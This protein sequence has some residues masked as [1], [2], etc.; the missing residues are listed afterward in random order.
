MKRVEHILSILAMLASVV[1]TSIA[2]VSLQRGGQTAARTT[3][4]EAVQHFHAARL[5][6]LEA[7]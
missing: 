7:Q 5:T 6:A 2:I 3:H 4:L 1:S